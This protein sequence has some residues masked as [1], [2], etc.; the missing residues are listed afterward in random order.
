MRRTGQDVSWSSSRG[1]QTET[2]WPAPARHVT[3]ETAEVNRDVTGSTT[4]SQWLRQ[5]GPRLTVVHLPRA[6]D[7]LKLSSLY[8]ILVACLH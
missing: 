7:H 4:M 1:V 6:A 2:R 5:S 8:S 3:P